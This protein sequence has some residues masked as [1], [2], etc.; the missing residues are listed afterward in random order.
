MI[1]VFMK[2]TVLLLFGG[3]SPEHEISVKTAYNVAKAI[4][5]TKFDIELVGI[6]KTGKF[7]NLELQHVEECAVKHETIEDDVGYNHAMFYENILIVYTSA[8]D[9]L[10]KRD[11]VHWLKSLEECISHK[12]IDA[13]FPLLHGVSG[14]DGVPQGFFNMLD[15]PFVGNDIK[16]SAICMDKDI[17][18]KLLK[19]EGI[20]VVDWITLYDGKDFSVDE[21][22]Q[23]LGLPLFIKAA[24]QGSSI[25]TYKARNKTELREYIIKAFTYGPKVILEKGLD[26]REIE[27]AV[28]GNDKDIEV[29]NPGEIIP[30]EKYGFYSYDA[31]YMDPDGAKTLTHT[32]LTKDQ[33]DLI[34]DYAKKAFTT[35]ECKGLARIDF[36]LHENTLYLNEVNT[37]PGFTNISMYP[38]LMME[39]GMTYQDLITQLIHL[40]FDHFNKK[41]SYSLV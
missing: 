34:Q 5:R 3:K 28:M 12:K 25:G 8:R 2:K 20:P 30:H 27:I 36:F 15:I 39:K 26:V 22:V 23:K 7:Y 17:T 19:A 9:F 40:A 13:V 32:N 33:I 41:K 1:R 14:E 4:D 16:S 24:E 35:L 21:I 29:S 11:T 37:M 31:K 18:K 10:K 38:R 6:S